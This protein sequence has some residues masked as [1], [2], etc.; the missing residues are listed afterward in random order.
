MYQE[1]DHEIFVV[2]G[3]MHFWDASPENWAHKHAE[4]WIRCFYDFH[5]S[6]S[7]D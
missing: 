2:D 5:T 4:G 6:L 1:N 7:P 3:H